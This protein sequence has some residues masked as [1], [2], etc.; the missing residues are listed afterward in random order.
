V[1]LK[2]HLG[3]T[4]AIARVKLVPE[5]PHFLKLKQAAGNGVSKAPFPYTM[6]DENPV[7]AQP[8]GFFYILVEM[9]KLDTEDFR[10]AQL[11]VFVGELLDVEVHFGRELCQFEYF[12]WHVAGRAKPA[13]FWAGIF[14][15]VR[16]EVFLSGVYFILQGF[17]EPKQV[18]LFIQKRS[19]SGFFE[20]KLGLDP[21]GFVHFA[22]CT[23]GGDAPA[24]HSYLGIVIELVKEQFSQFKNRRVA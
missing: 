15:G 16:F 20:K 10:I 24:I 21:Q 5:A 18:H 2:D 7:D 8:D 22:A 23:L 6:Y 14:L 13:G 1:K 19:S 11:M 4:V 9:L 17:E 3:S 12:V